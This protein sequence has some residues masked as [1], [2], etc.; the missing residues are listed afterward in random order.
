MFHYL[1]L[2]TKRLLLYILEYD[3]NIFFSYQKF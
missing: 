2:Y 1:S 3:E